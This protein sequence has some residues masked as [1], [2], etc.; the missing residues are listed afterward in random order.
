MA[1]RCPSCGA[2]NPDY[3][4]YCGSCAS[5]LHDVP[6]EKSGASQQNAISKGGLDSAA[7]H[8]AKVQQSMRRVALIFGALAVLL[9][10][11]SILDWKFDSS[12]YVN[13]CLAGLLAVVVVWSYWVST[14]DEA[15]AF[16]RFGGWI[17]NVSA[18]VAGFSLNQM[19]LFLTAVIIG[20]ILGLLGILSLSASE[21]TIALAIVIAMAGLFFSVTFYGSKVTL[22]DTGI[23]IGLMNRNRLFIPF[24]R[25]SSIM[26]KKNVLTVSLT[27]AP[28]LS[29]RT[30]KFLLLG[31]IETM[32]NELDRVAP[33]G[34]P[35][36]ILASPQQKRT[37]PVKSEIVFV[38]T[39]GSNLTLAGILLI[40]AGFFAFLTAAIFFVW[41]SHYSS[42]GG[43]PFFCCGSLEIAFG[44]IAI[45]G[46]LL[47][48]RR[49]KYNLAMTAAVLAII[50]G[51]MG[52]SFVLGIV[53]AVMIRRSREDFR[54]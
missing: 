44:A 35:T 33:S 26:L 18:E 2:E 45:L 3:V 32:R 41:D 11:E 46:G 38:G 21:T 4:T 36:H 1:M 49:V 14:N 13:L 27:K 47:S 5:A 52:I 24:D 17:G 40:A 54:D 9:T 10:A 29:Y 20:G 42:P 25:V 43:S 50:S 39:G 37:G 19:L 48:L 8:K 51:G 7:E 15:L 31:N 53:A 30:H 6:T 22:E 28:L 23:C 16:I 12:D 34:T